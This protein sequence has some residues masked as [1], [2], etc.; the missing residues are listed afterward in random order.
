MASASPPPRTLPALEK[1]SRFFWKAGADGRLLILRCGCGHYQHPPLPRCPLCGSEAVAP[2][3]VSGHGRIASFTVNWQAWRPGMQVPF[4]FA[5]VE[6]C[7]QAGLYLFTN[8]IGCP[9]EAVRI[10][11]PVEVVFEA[12][13]DVWLPMFRPGG[14]R[15]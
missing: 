15:D 10:G 11:M 3:P 12:D 7:E 14:E 6:L 9:A 4:V 13:G 1:D 8:I 2:Q 5:A